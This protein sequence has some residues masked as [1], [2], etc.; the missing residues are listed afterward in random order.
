MAGAGND[1]VNAGNGN[2]VI[3]GGAGKDVLTGG[4]GTDNLSGGSGSDLLNAG[5][6]DDDGDVAALKTAG[7]N[8]VTTTGT[9]SLNNPADDGVVDTLTGGLNPDLIIHA[10]NDVLNGFVNGVDTEIIN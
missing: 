5:T 1:T 3:I 4:D 7:Q 6:R 8:W 10:A 2:D 9:N